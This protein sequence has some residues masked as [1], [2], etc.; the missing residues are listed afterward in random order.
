[1]DINLLIILL[2]WSAD[3]S[4]YPNPDTLPEIRLEPHSFFVE[5]VCGGKE[6]KAVGWYNDTGVIYIDERYWN[7]DGDEESSLLVHEFTHH[8]QY[9]NGVTDTCFRE[10]QAY[11]VQNQ[12][13]AIVLTNMRRV[14]PTCSET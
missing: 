10:Y 11:W 2:S 1:M 3:L 9:L 13:N 6:C 5:N 14:R 12:Y 8:L 4:G 7:F